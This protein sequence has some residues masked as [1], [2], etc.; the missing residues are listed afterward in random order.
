ML[1]GERLHGGFVLVRMANDRE[2]GKRTNWLLIKHRDEFAVEANGAAVL[3]ENDTSVASG[4][5]MEAIAAGK[6][7]KPKPFMLQGG[8]VQADAVWDSRSGLAAEKR[9][10]G[11]QCCAPPAG[12]PLKGSCPSV[13]MPPTSLDG[14]THG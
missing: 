2:R 1:K 3:E 11:K 8:E 7:R 5:P 9:K 13:E 12:C 4:R 10:E 6:G 14:H